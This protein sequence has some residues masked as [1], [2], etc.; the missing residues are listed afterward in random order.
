MKIYSLFIMICFTCLV[1]NAQEIIELN[2]PS[3]EGIPMASKAPFAWVNGNQFQ[4]SPPDIQPGWFEVEKEAYHGATYMGMVT[5]NNASW[6]SVGQ[7][8]SSPLLKGQDYSFSIFLAQSEKYESVDKSAYDNGSGKIKIV[9]YTNPII[10]RVWGSN[11]Y[12]LKDE[13]LVQTKPVNHT[14]WKP[15]SL[16]FNPGNEYQFIIFEAYYVDDHTSPYSGHILLDNCSA[17]HPKST[18]KSE[19][20]QDTNILKNKEIL[21]YYSSQD[22]YS[23]IPYFHKKGMSKNDPNISF[24]HLEILSNIAGFQ[25]HSFS[26]VQTFYNSHSSNEINHFIDQ[27]EHIGIEEPMNVIKRLAFVKQ[28]EENGQKLKR[29]DKQ[30]IKEY[31]QMY[32]F[33]P[34][35]IN[36]K[37]TQYIQQNK[38]SII[39]EIVI[40]LE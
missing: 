21:H 25:Q 14:T 38:E 4:E 13:L 19:T 37:A 33:L 24:S 32:R 35:S 18:P 39:N 7:K 27:L 40:C 30:F 29:R 10:L 3:F 2:N 23:Y 17:I 5:R 20:E 8:L 11:S 15:Y 22:I 9:S 6:E 28:Q 36:E 1:T 34:K 31:K 16:E 26:S 12:D